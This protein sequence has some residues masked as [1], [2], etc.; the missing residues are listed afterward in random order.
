MRSTGAFMGV[1]AAR[2]GSSAPGAQETGGAV[3]EATG[4]IRRRQ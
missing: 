4:A 2:V 1:D 3:V